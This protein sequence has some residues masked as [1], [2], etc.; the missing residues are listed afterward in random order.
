MGVFSSVP[1]AVRG[2]PVP[3]RT[4]GTTNALNGVAWS[5]TQFVAVGSGG[6]ILTSPD[7]TT[8]TSRTL[9]TSTFLGAFLQGTFLQGVTWSGTQFV[10]VGSG[11]TVLTSPDGITWT[12]HFSQGA[13]NILYGVAWSGTQFVAVGSVGTIRTSPY[14]ITWTSQ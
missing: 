4:T 2:M 5:G 6:T 12:S 10:A 14:G 3:S 8:W 7:G 9:D 11:G 13:T 1:I